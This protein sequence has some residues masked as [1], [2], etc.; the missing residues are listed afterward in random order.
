ML[1]RGKCQ[2][3]SRVLTQHPGRRRAGAAAPRQPRARSW[4]RRAA[5]SHS[6]SPWCSPAPGAAAAAP[7]P[8]CARGYTPRAGGESHRGSSGEAELTGKLLSRQ[9]VHFQALR[10]W[11]GKMMQGY[12][13]TFLT[14]I[15]L[16]T[17]H[18]QKA[19]RR[20]EQRPTVCKLDHR[21]QNPADYRLSGVFCRRGRSHG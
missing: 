20:T 17:Q 5:G 1:Y 4:R 6:G 19:L 12:C 3:H 13:L 15:Y 9:L 21:E 18:L 16:E 14:G 10:R 8:P 2:Q 7:P 11:P